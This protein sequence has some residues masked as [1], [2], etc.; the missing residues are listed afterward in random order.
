MVT[1]GGCTTATTDAPADA[2]LAV[3]QGA[4]VVCVPGTEA[5][6]HWKGVC[7]DA[8]TACKCHDPDHWTPADNCKDWHEGFVADGE[9][10]IPGTGSYCN[11]NGICTAD[12]LGCDCADY[13]H[14]ATCDTTADQCPG[15]GQQVGG[16][17]SAE[18][19]NGHGT[20]TGPGVCVCDQGYTG[21]GCTLADVDPCD[22]NP[23]ANGGT[24]AGSA[25]GFECT[26]VG[27]YHGATCADDIDECAEGTDDCE[28][29]EMCVNTIGGFDCTDVVVDATDATVQNLEVTGT[30][31]LPAGS[32]CDPDTLCDKLIGV[33]KLDADAPA[34]GQVL[35][36][37]GT[38]FE[39]AADKDTTYKAGQGIVIAGA[40]NQI[41]LR[42]ASGSLG[43]V[44]RRICPSGSAMNAI[45]G[46]GNFT[47]RPFSSTTYTA[48]PGI[49]IGGS[50]N[51]IYLRPPHHTGLLGGVKAVNC[52]SGKVNGISTDGHAVCRPDADT[53]Y[54]PGSGLTL[55]TGNRFNVGGLTNSHIAGG[56]AIAANKISGVAATL[57]GNQYFDTNTL[58]IRADA[59]RV[60]IGTSIP[61]AKLEVT[62]DVMASQFRYKT[63]KTA[64][65]SVPPHAFRSVSGGDG[66][67]AYTDRAAY[68][69]ACGTLSACAITATAPVMLPDGAVRSSF[70]CYYRD[71]TSTAGFKAGTRV[72]LY[73]R[74]VSTEGVYSSGDPSQ[75]TTTVLGTNGT[76]QYDAG[77]PGGDT[78][79]NGSKMYTLVLNLNSTLASSGL[80][81]YGCRIGYTYTQPLP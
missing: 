20:C 55:A 60:G 48:G 43:G 6:C 21:A 17:W 30:V 41:H 72:R 15:Y 25:T 19:C 5:Y 69:T 7:N 79:A 56:A 71:A 74:V 4:L 34:P 73:S 10:C 66:Y 42:A 37:D 57:A 14:G 53:K 77:A 13:H 49:G 32:L 12:G 52:G 58:A 80:R 70:G 29:G 11:N 39:W 40:A 68:P 24:C 3:Q 61:A 51:Q 38:G 2:L 78:I 9:V 62:G 75:W 46:G 45:D 54:A 31:T 8:G 22:P 36:Y 63:S 35:S 44:R 23:C 67:L 47:C 33:S 26:C 16:S 64:Y 81:F 59:N 65:L 1:V 18:V 50:G 27:G 28:A 76:V